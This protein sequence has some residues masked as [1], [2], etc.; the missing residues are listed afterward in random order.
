MSYSV[1]FSHILELVIVSA[2]VSERLGQVEIPLTNG[3]FLP[4]VT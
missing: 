1:C 2:I 3:R 4:P